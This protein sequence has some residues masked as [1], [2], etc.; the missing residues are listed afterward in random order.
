MLGLHLLRMKI[1]IFKCFCLI[2]LVIFHL[3]FSE[4]I[5][6]KLHNANCEQNYLSDS[7]DADCGGWV[8]MAPPGLDQSMFPPHFDRYL[9][10]LISPP[11]FLNKFEF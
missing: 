4:L 11:I 5:A 1:Y 10:V 8:G 2:A 9:S 3:S 7:D 6:I